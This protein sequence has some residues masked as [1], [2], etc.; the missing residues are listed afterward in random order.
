MHKKE[1]ALE[2]LLTQK[3]LPLF[4]HESADISENVLRALYT[5]GIRLVE[6]TNRGTNALINFKLLR[7]VVETEMP[8]LLLGIGTIKNA[9]QAKQYIDAGADFIVS[10]STNV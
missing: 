6:Y 4:Y 3:I 2:A 8:G 9:E 7:K 10:P 5:G 1:K